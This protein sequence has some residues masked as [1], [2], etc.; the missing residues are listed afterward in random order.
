[1]TYEARCTKHEARLLAMALMAVCSSAALAMPTKEELG[2]AQSLVVELMAD[3]VAAF[4]AKS[5]KAEEIG[6]TSVKYAQEASTEAAK[7]LL[8]KGAISYYVRGESYD[9]AADAVNALRE[10]VP[11]VP[12]DVLEEVIRKN[13]ARVTA[14][15]AP[16]LYAM[17]QT[18]QVQVA[19]AKEVK[20][21]KAALAKKPKDEAAIRK[22]AE[23]QALSGDWKA[24]LGTFAKLGSK[25][26]AM[27]K[28]ETEGK[29]L[30]SVADFW[31]AYESYLGEEDADAF[32]MHAAAIYRKCLADGLID[33]LKKNIV[34]K[35]IKGYD[36]G[37]GIKDLTPTTGT[38]KDGPDTIDLQVVGADPIRLIKC[39]AGA[40]KMGFGGRNAAFVAHDVVL[41]RS[42]WMSEAPI[43]IGQYTA[44]MGSFDV[45]F[46]PR[47]GIKPRDGMRKL[48]DAMGGRACA[49]S[50]VTV[51]EID[52]YCEKLSAKFK[53]SIPQ[54][55]IV[56]LPTEAEWIY[57]FKC[58]GHVKEQNYAALAEGAEAPNYREI[59]ID[60]RDVLAKT[61][62]DL[63]ISY[64]Q[65]KTSQIGFYTPRCRVK[66]RKP[67]DWGFYDMAG[68]C[69]ER[70][71]DRVSA[72]YAG[73]ATWN[74][75][76]KGCFAELNKAFVAGENSDPLL[77]TAEKQGQTLSIRC[78]QKNSGKWVNESGRLWDVGF[79]L[80]IGPDLVSEWKAKNAKK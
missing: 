57:A 14:K 12:P 70:L 59:G 48:A 69:W 19:A 72:S 66:T 27:A 10:A 2:K 43:T 1:M 74:K 54:G 8:L 67:N 39:P 58:G 37:C 76:G 78:D 68:L 79:R 46:E 60:Y 56:R 50:G 55:Y 15:K 17:Y 16:R 22:L 25:S 40:F 21:A 75:R 32:K 62:A 80:V 5:K 65:D 23:A 41:T 7:F 53:R 42:F 6:D 73:S 4:K 45:L 35:R 34:E 52:R 63:G 38:K 28:S 49:I 3:D 31:W 20:V 18:V 61:I 13:T 29:D 71:A 44:V 24:A 26:G 11:D 36:E 51:E 47:F 30:P 77:V 64:S 9:K 33:G